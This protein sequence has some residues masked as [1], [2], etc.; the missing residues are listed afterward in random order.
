MKSYYRITEDELL[1]EE[2]FPVKAIFNM[3]KDDRFRDIVKG[4][5]NNSGFGENY[6]ACVFW[7]DLDDFDKQNTP[8]YEGAEFGLHSGEEII[9]DSKELL[10]YLNLV[11]NKY[12]KDHLDDKKIIWEYVNKQKQNNKLS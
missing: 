2:H 9:I 5:S 12:C 3:V 4:I 8:F 11:C 6:G 1:A 10:Y 7:N